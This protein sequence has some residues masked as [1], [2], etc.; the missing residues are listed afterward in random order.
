MIRVKGSGDPVA[1]ASISIGYGAPRQSDSVVSDAQGR[2]TAQ[3]PAGDVTMHVVSLNESF[4]QIGE[5]WAKRYKVPE[6]AEAFDLPP[7]EVVRGLT[8]KG[9]LVDADDRPMTNVGISVIS[10]I[11]ATKLRHARTRRVRSP[12]LGSCPISS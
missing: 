9:R 5:P 2:F 4:V 6:G 8:I 10:T 7:I 11:A 3:G 1:G 12:C